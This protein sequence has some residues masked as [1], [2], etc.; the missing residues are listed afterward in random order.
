MF[1]SFF[2]MFFIYL[3]F[4]NRKVVWADPILRI[5]LLILFTYLVV[6]GISVANFGTGIRHRMKFVVMFILLA[7]PLLP[8]FNFSRK[9]KMKN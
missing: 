9:N 5:I 3:I 4:R 2:Y 6:Y 1:D 7:G 8:K